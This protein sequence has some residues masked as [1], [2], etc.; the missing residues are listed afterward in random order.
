[1]CKWYSARSASSG[2]MKAHMPCA[3]A[4]IEFARIAK[5]VKRGLEQRARRLGH[6]PAAQVG[7]EVREYF[8]VAPS[9]P[10]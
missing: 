3:T 1:M 10:M 9:A 2:D 4:E 7:A 8:E 6:A 5:S